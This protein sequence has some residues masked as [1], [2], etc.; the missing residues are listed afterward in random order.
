MEMFSAIRRRVTYTNVALTIGLVFAMSGGAY[1]ASKYLITS[2]KQ[3]SPKV[4]AQLKGAKGAK[5]AAGAAGASGPQGPAGAQGPAGPQ[6]PAGTNGKDGA[7][8]ATGP[9]GPKGANG[10]TG[11]TETLPSGKTETGAWNISV[12]EETEAI[13]AISFPIPLP[14]ALDASHVHYVSA[15]G[16]KAVFYNKTSEEWEVASTPSCPGTDEEPKAAPGNLCIYGAYTGNIVNKGENIAENVIAN[17][18]NP[19][20]LVFREYSAGT[21]GALLLLERESK[22]GSAN[23]V[24]TW[25]VTAP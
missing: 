21:S 9:Q 7:P 22:N 15:D 17:P 5:G 18:T 14:E 6:G 16:T 1:A 4:L 12:G 3:I 2:T 24:G 13:T 8:G 10:Q 11:F 19:V 23:G 25:A 20:A